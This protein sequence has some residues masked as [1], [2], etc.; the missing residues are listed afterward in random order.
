MFTL[1][2]CMWVISIWLYNSA[3]TLSALGISLVDH[4]MMYITFWFDCLLD[5]KIALFLFYLCE[6]FRTRTRFY[7]NYIF[8]RSAFS[9]LWKNGP[10]S[11]KT[12]HCSKISTMKKKKNC[13][14]NTTTRVDRKR[15]II[16]ICLFGEEI[17]GNTH[18]TWIN[19]D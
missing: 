7:F 15:H 10:V 4:A 16:V 18:N 1:R 11:G 12:A 6:V 9:L 13:Q 19:R 3:I 8:P 2:I 17:C 5:N 14:A